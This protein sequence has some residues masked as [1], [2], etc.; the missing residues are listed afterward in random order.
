MLRQAVVLVGGRG[1]C[2]GELTADTSKPMWA[3]QRANNGVSRDAPANSP[4]ALKWSM[5]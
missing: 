5:V 4:K 3:G 1:T 2:L